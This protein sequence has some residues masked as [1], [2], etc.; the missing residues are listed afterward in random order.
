M[1]LCSIRPSPEHFSSNKTCFWKVA[2]IS[3]IT[4]RR[5]LAFHGERF[6]EYSIVLFKLIHATKDQKNESALI[7]IDFCSKQL[8][9]G[10]SC[11]TVLRPRTTSFPLLKPW[12]LTR[13]IKTCK[14]SLKTKDYLGFMCLQYK[15]HHSHFVIFIENVCSLYVSSLS[16][17]FKPRIMNKA[18]VCVHI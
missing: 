2:S 10:R 14:L 16:M 12:Q 6:W 11:E 3:G 8:Q 13:L 17:T 7:E 15:N 9:Y 5:K 4:V 18:L 1:I